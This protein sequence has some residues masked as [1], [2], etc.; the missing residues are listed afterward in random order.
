MVAMLMFALVNGS[1]VIFVLVDGS[2]EEGLFEEISSVCDDGSKCFFD[3][4]KCD[5]INDCHDKSDEQSC[6]QG[7]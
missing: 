1:C 6:E 3:L 2:C 5:E 4:D 7:G